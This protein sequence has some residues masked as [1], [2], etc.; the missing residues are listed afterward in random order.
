MMV[1]LHN[2]ESLAQST[3][4]ASTRKSSRKTSASRVMKQGFEKL[5]ITNDASSTRSARRQQYKPTR[6]SQNRNQSESDR[7]RGR[8]RPFVPT[9]PPDNTISMSSSGDSGSDDKLEPATDGLFA[10]LVLVERR[11]VAAQLQCS[12][13]VD[14]DGKTII[15]PAETWRSLISLH[16]AYFAEL[17]DY[18]LAS[19][20]PDAKPSL[21]QKAADNNIPFRLWKVGIHSFLEL[22]RSRL[23]D[24]L[25]YFLQFIYVVF[26]NLTLLIETVPVYRD[27]WVECL[28]DVS[29]YRMAIEDVNRQERDFWNSIARYYYQ[30]SADSNPRVGRLNHHLA[31]LAR[32]NMLLQLYLYA[33]SLTV[34]EP[35]ENSR[36]SILTLFR[37]VLFGTVFDH[38]CY[39]KPDIHFIKVVGRLYLREGLENVDKMIDDFTKMLKWS[40]NSLKARWQEHGPYMVISTVAALLDY[41]VSDAF[42]DMPYIAVSYLACL[43]RL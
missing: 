28:G 17:Y 20:H 15:L 35:F 38:P 3:T 12:K 8:S 30:L 42:F 22:F 1:E 29:R 25:E 34:A 10:A 7:S 16:K 19:H 24:S 27:T 32:P 4:R 6:R 39:H 31:I 14:D 33:K 40:L 41:G 2:Q 37:P 26:V 43:S 11:C 36:N 23:P 18:L 5:T 9:L 21:R 13:L